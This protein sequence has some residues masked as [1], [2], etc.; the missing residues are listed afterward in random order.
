[1]P[2]PLH[3]WRPVGSTRCPQLPDR[4][5]VPWINGPCVQAHNDW[6]GFRTDGIR[7]HDERLCV[8]CGDPLGQRI[9]LGSMSGGRVTAGP[10]GHPHCIRL[11]VSTCPHLVE[12]DSPDATVAF[13]YVG[14]D[15]GYLVDDEEELALS[16]GQGEQISA[17]ARPL[18]R[19]QVHEIA[20]ADPWG[21]GSP[22]KPPQT[23]A[24]VPSCPFAALRI[25]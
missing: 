6:H 11:A 22:D 1:L 19:A 4:L 24:A 7:A 12:R 5:P 10:G 16:Y 25:A 23:Q 20:K 17:E 14:D 15:V 13:E 9:L 8:V 3:H 2:R 21:S 18:T